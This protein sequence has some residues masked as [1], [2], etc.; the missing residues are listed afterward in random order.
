MSIKINILETNVSI[1]LDHAVAKGNII[2]SHA[3]GPSSIT[4]RVIFLVDVFPG[5]SVNCKTNVRKTFE[6]FVTMVFD[7]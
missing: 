7:L 3:A 1:E 2:T 6:R 4:D 5:F